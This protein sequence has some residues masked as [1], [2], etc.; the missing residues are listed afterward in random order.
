MLLI[1]GRGWVSMGLF[2]VGLSLSLVRRYGAI[3]GHLRDRQD[4]L[5]KIKGCIVDSGGDPVIDPKVCAK[6]CS[7]D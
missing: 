4:L 2:C 1:G 3:L 7:G 5:E 6:S